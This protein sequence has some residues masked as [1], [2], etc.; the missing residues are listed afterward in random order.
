MS[1]AV[2]QPLT[3]IISVLQ[4][5][6]FEQLFGQSVG[7]MITRTKVVTEKGDKPSLGQIIVRNL[8]RLIPLEAFSFL[9]KNPVGWHDSLSKTLVVNKSQIKTTPVDNKKVLSKKENKKIPLATIAFISI[10]VIIFGLSQYL[11]WKVKND[12]NEQVVELM[13]DKVELTRS[14]NQGATERL[15]DVLL[16]FE[17]EKRETTG[18]NMVFSASDGES[19][20]TIHKIK[21]EENVSFQDLNREEKAL[22]ADEIFKGAK[23]EFEGVELIDSGFKKTVFYDEVFFMA[24][25]RTIGDSETVN[26]IYQIF[27]GD[28]Y[29]LTTITPESSFGENRLQIER[30]LDSFKLM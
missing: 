19:I 22:Y 4:V 18:K 8:A 6:V 1:Y 20:L 5:L 21:I 25:E 2:F 15:V 13:H 17:W 10:P 23:N 11:S 12:V 24:Y 26:L 9:A 27:D 29:T 14:E 7:K 28:L 3:I 16:P 30:I